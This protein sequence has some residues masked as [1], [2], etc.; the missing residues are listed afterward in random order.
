MNH[1][2]RNE[3]FS[4]NN[5]ILCITFTVGILSNLLTIIFTLFSKKSNKIA[6]KFTINLGVSDLL[7]I[8]I[9]IPITIYVNYSPF[10]WVFGSIGCKF[11][12]YIQGV[13]VSSSI[14]TITVISIDRYIIICKPLIVRTSYTNRK[15]NFIILMIWIFSFII[16]LPFPLVRRTKTF[17]NT[18][19]NSSVA[20]VSYC[21]EDWDY[22]E[23]KL[24][25]E[26]GL[27][28]IHFIIPSV[29]ISSTLIC[30]AK[31]LWKGKVEFDSELTCSVKKKSIERRLSS[32]TTQNHGDKRKSENYA[33]ENLYFK[34]EVDK[35]FTPI[36]NKNFHRQNSLYSKNDSIANGYDRLCKSRKKVVVLVLSLFVLF[37]VSWLPYHFV[38]ITSE[39]LIYAKLSNNKNMNDTYLI[40]FLNTEI[41]PYT[42]CFAFSNSALNGIIFCLFSLKFRKLLSLISGAC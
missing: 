5:S 24:I 39:A 9:C 38:F 25:F 28:I 34:P 26:A 21:Y 30:I 33:L 4:I 8:L 1:F 10:E 6:R 22:V 15:V 35:S 32:L 41:H 16:N 14:L 40:Q 12:S 7:I 3:L 42:T 29:I 17:E 23:V 36:S 19:S 20:F 31:K 18:E 13:A 11:A 37:I 2:Y 27:I